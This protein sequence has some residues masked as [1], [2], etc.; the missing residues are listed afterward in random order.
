MDGRTIKRNASVF[1]DRS[2]M[3][4]PRA[5]RALTRRSLCG[6]DLVDGAEPARASCVGVNRDRLRG[7]TPLQLQRHNIGLNILS[8]RWN[9]NPVPAGSRTIVWHRDVQPNQ[10]QVTG[11]RDV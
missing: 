10:Y 11:K 3:F 9:G 4:D 8:F 6:V 1:D 5:R 2:F 7:E